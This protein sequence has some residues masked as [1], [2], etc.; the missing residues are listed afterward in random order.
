MT[1]S[2][3]KVPESL[4]GSSSS[5]AAWREK[6]GEWLPVKKEV[7]TST[8][9]IRPGNASL[10]MHQSCPVH[11]RTD[12][13]SSSCPYGSE[14]LLSLLTEFKPVLPATR[15]RLDSHPSIHFPNSVYL[16]GM[17]TAGSWFKRFS[18]TA[19]HS[20]A[21]EWDYLRFKCDRREPPTSQRSA[22][23]PSQRALGHQTS[24]G[25]GP[26]RW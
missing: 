15:F 24:R 22:Y 12:Y 7:S 9:R 4:T 26:S 10:M 25:R 3:F 16:S 17:K 18:A 19:N 5:S 1:K 8:P 23:R 2:I 20:V 14:G 11:A 6:R 21:V 13:V